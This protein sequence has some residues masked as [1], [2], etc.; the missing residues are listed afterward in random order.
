MVLT[1]SSVNR[2][3][4]LAE[5]PKIFDPVTL[6][7]YGDPGL[8]RMDIIINLLWPPKEQS[9][10]DRSNGLRTDFSDHAVR[11]RVIGQTAGLNQCDLITE[12]KRSM[13]P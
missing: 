1:D 12:R 13:I 9:M 11:E 4:G 2:G 7:G 6:F 3:L 5:L 8:R 10:L